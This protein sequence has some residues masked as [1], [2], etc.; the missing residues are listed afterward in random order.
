MSKRAKIAFALIIIFAVSLFGIK[1]YLD[2]T[3]L[4]QYNRGKVIGEDRFDTMKKISERGWEKS[5][6]AI[7]VSIHSVVDGTSVAPFAYQKNIPVFFSDLEG[8]NDTI[9]DELTRLG[10]KNVYLIGGKKVVTNDVEKEI[11]KMGITTE[12]IGGRDGFETSLELAKRLNELNPISEVVFVNM[13]TGKPN[14]VSIAPAA[15]RKN[16][17]ILLQNKS[18]RKEI[19]KFLKENNIKKIYLTGNED[20][21]SAAFVK[22]L[23][24]DK[25]GIKAEV[26]R[27]NGDDRYETN[28]DIIN[29][30]YKTNKLNNIYVLRSGV[31]N[32]ADFLNALALSPIAARENTPILYSGDSLQ[33][34][35]QEF[36]EKN[37]IRDITEVG[38]EL[39]RPRIISEKVV[40]S[41]SAIAIVVL[42]I[43]A[44][45]RIIFQR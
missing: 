36:L 25:H 18:D 12:R 2:Q 17:P 43:L 5:D 7:I 39:I 37:N 3:Y 4:S 35:E 31:Y 28:K 20:V 8:L 6:E 13:K 33:K 27:L 11:K 19:L 16:M 22:M 40:S 38:F 24:D 44:L 45:R 23:K 14:G 29:E 32:Y 34:T 15:A 30:F 21:F 9:K 26:V 10:V 42:W 1:I 41:I